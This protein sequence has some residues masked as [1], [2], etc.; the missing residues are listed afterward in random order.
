M[1]SIE[2]SWNAKFACNT[3]LS[4]K[5]NV[6]PHVSKTMEIL[7][8]MSNVLDVKTLIVSIVLQMLR[9]VSNATCFTHYQEDNV[10]IHAVQIKEMC[11]Q[12]ISRQFV[13]QLQI[14]CAHFT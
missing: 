1:A 12:I 9:F 8:L 7:W 13:S 2:N 3:L 14:P 4:F 11:T 5:D 6:F 10:T